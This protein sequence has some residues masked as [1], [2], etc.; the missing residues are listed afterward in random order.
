MTRPGRGSRSPEDAGTPASGRRHAPG[1]PIAEPDLP[2]DVVRSGPYRLTFARTVEELRALQRLRFEVFNLEL[3][4]GLAASLESG[5]D[6]DDLDDVMHHILISDRRTGAVV[7]TY[8]MQTAAMAAANSGFYTARE[9]DFSQFPMEIIDDAVE[10]GR[11]CIAKDHR[12]RRVLHLL[13]RGLAVYLTRTG[14]HHLF[15]CCSLTTQDGRVGNAAHAFLVEGGH[16][17]P[18]ARAWPLPG[19]ECGLH[20]HGDAPEEPVDIPPLFQSYLNLGAKI[21]GPPAIDRAFR[22]ID[23]LVVLDVRELERHVFRSFFR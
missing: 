21:C 12:S 14:K 1:F 10:V 5:L 19:F 6:Q 16:L 22:T 15:G 4:E 23:F 11:A 3:G 8:R 17:H 2:R 13:W 18:H 7:G 9:F 20:D